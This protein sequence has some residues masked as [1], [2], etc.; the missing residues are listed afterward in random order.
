MIQMSSDSLQNTGY[1]LL[2]ITN[3]L[4]TMEELANPYKARPPEIGVLMIALPVAAALVLLLNLPAVVAEVRQVR[5][6]KPVRL[7]EEE[8]RTVGARS[9]YP[10]GAYEPLGLTEC[11][12]LR[13]VASIRIR[14]Y[15]NATGGPSMRKPISGG[16]SADILE[17]LTA[18][19]RRIE[20]LHHRT[21]DETV[22]TGCPAL[23]RLL[24][25][26]GLRRGTLVEWLAAGAGSGAATLAWI[27]AREACRAGGRAGRA[28]R[29]GAGSIRRRPRRSASIWKVC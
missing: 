22:T 24:P 5:I 17:R 28:R 16:T 3:P 9:R 6:A 11:P 23:D 4:W 26:A 25:G 12:W 7:A 2:Q 29:P 27:A 14:M 10:D 18:E 19:V 1:S 21:S 15:T 20:G 8:A 13:L